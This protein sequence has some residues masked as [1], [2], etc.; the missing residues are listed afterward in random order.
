LHKGLGVRTQLS[1]SKIGE[2][3]PPPEGR[4]CAFFFSVNKMLTPEA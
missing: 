1:S 4:A 2:A 3:T